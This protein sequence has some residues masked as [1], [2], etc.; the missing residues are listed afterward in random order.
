MNIR[1]EVKN[2]REGEALRA[3]LAD[4]QVR[5]FVQVVGVLNGLSSDRARARVLVVPVGPSNR[6]R[7]DPRRDRVP[8]QTRGR[9]VRMS[10][11]VR[12]RREADELRAGLQDPIARAFVRVLGRIQSGRVRS[13]RRRGRL[14]GIVAADRP[15]PREPE[16]GPQT[17]QD[18]NKGQQG[19][20]QDNQR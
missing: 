11:D 9:Q 10:L 1:I 17:K 16:T 15:P 12:T 14:R 8:V 20:A 2:R 18:P 6:D 7:A 5:A 13:G 19:T 3:G 4:P